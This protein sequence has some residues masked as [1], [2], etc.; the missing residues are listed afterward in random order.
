MK[1]TLAEHRSLWES[2]AQSV[3]RSE[4]DWE[5][6]YPGWLDILSDVEAML[7]ADATPVQQDL[8][9][10]FLGRDHE[11]ERILDLLISHP[12]GGEPIA[13]RAASSP[14]HEARWQA[15][16]A[17]GAIGSPTALAALSTLLTDPH[18]YV[19]R[20]A[21]LAARDSLPVLAEQI[22]LSW[23]VSDNEYSRAVALE[24]LSVIGSP[25]LSSA[26]QQLRS[27]P[28]PVVRKRAS[29]LEQ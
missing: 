3:D 14:D 17:L 16:V 7:K 9:I 23:L 11:D 22:S 27:D 10:F 13:A 28:S 5:S 25:H 8:V 19:R 12:V 2:W 21:L 6:F 26:L 4:V 20:R 29:N 18:E 24:T 15:G 1:M